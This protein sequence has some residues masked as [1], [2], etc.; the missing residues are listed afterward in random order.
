MDCIFCNI[1]GGEIPTEFVYE[2]ADVVAFRD[3]HPIA[4]VHLLVIPKKHI[5]SLSEVT[6]EDRDLLGNIQIVLSRL[7]RQFG[8]AESGYRVVT[9]IGKDGGQTV[10]HLHYHLIGGEKLRDFTS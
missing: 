7:A 6:E 2:D 10:G 4:P 5:S 8:I 1:A 3:I 9:N